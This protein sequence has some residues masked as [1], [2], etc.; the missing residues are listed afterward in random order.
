[1][2]N[3]PRIYEIY[4]HYMGIMFKYVRVGDVGPF[5]LYSV[6]SMNEKSAY[7]HI[8]RPNSQGYNNRIKEYFQEGNNGKEDSQKESS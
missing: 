6:R 8:Q 1:M 2:R 7:N 3:H 5:E 4:E